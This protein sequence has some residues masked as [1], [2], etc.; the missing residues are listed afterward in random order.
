MHGGPNVCRSAGQ[1]FESAQ[2]KAAIFLIE[3]ELI[4]S[5]CYLSKIANISK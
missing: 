1:G 5:Q 3:S 4:T 2:V